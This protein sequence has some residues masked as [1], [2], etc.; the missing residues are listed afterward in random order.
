MNN[1]PKYVVSKSLKTP[2]WNN[3]TIIHDN[4]LDEIS[5]IKQLPGKDILVA[6][7]AELVNTL[8]QNNL[9]DEYR[10]MVHPVILGS[11]K[12]L[13][14]DTGTRKIM[15]LT[16]TKSFSTGIVVLTYHPV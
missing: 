2:E 9:A 14:L 13:F 4:I 7:S 11:G 6:G 5:K 16:D 15:K 1:L 3:T 12:R 8:M 10:L